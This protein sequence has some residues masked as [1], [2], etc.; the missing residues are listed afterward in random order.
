M[1]SSIRTKQQAADA[2]HIVLPGAILTFG[3]GS[4]KDKRTPNNGKTPYLRRPYSVPVRDAGPCLSLPITG[5]HRS[6]CVHA[7]DVALALPVGY[8]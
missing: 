1:A 5:I 4:R 7:G 6:K 8:V 2:L 3:A